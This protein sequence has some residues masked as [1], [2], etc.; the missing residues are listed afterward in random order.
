[1]ENEVV[2]QTMEIV[3]GPEHGAWTLRVKKYS[4]DEEARIEFAGNPT[5]SEFKKAFEV[6]AKAEVANQVKEAIEKVVEAMKI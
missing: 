6:L 4:S 5:L 1:M 3:V 2:V